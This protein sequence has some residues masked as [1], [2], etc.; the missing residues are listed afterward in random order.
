MARTNRTKPLQDRQEKFCL[1]YLKDM[2]AT[3]AAVRAGYSRRTCEVQGPRLLGNVRI[4]ARVQQLLQKR[5]EKLELKTDDVL[6]ELLRIATVDVSKIYG[7]DG[8][9]LPIHEMPEDVRRAIAGVDVL[10]HGDGETVWTTK[11]VRFWD[12]T[13]ALE[14]LAKVLKLLTENVNVS[15]SLNLEQLLAKAGQPKEK[16]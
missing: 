10:S 14:L 11:K 4:A 5:N 6:R 15:G 2:N 13:K 8:L 9:L 12:K 7:P 3:Q 1:E 16:S